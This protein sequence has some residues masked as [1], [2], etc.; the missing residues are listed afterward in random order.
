MRCPSQPA[1]SALLKSKPEFAVKLTGHHSERRCHPVTISMLGSG[2]RPF[3]LTKIMRRYVPLVLVSVLTFSSLSVH[4]QDRDLTNLDLDTLMGMDVAVTSATRRA[5]A[6]ADAAAAVYV[7]TREDIRRSGA[8]TLPE[9]LRYVPG[10]H[11]A[12][13]NSR[14]WAVTSRGSS[15]R[16]ANKLLVMI[17]GRSLYSSVFSGVLWEEQSV[18]LEEI[19]RI[20][21]VRGPGGALWGIN[22]VNGVI[23]VI[24]R[25]AADARGLRATGGA[26]SL[27]EQSAAVSYGSSAE[28]VGDYRTYVDHSEVDGIGASDAWSHTQA[29]VRVDRELANGSFTLQGDIN[30]ADFGAPPPEPAAALPGSAQTG[31]LLAG[32]QQ[33]TQG[34]QLELR[35]FYAWTRRGSPSRWAESLLGFDLQFAAERS[36]AH[37]LTM[38]AGYRRSVDELKEPWSVLSTVS[39]KVVQDQWSIF[40]QDEIHLANDRVRFIAGAKLEDHEFSGLAFQPTLRGLWAVTDSHTVWLAGSRAVRTPSRFELSAHTQI[41][42]FTPEGM[43][44]T[45]QVFGDQNLKAEDLHAYEF[46]WRWRPLQTISVDLALYRHEYEHLVVPQPLAA[47]VEFLPTPRLLLPSQFVNLGETFSEGAELSLEWVATNWMRMEAQGTWQTQSG[48]IGVYAPRDPKRMFSVQTSLD[49]PFDTELDLDWRSV[50]ALPGI[51][52]YEVL[53]TRLAWWL[54]T[55]IEL[56]FSVDNIFDDEHVEFFDDIAL[57]PGATLGRS[58]FARFTVRP[59]R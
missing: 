35:G 50:A 54:T 44:L 27:H 56:S 59:K 32:W 52:G 51:D 7:I 11:V 4:G 14:G 25:M 36:G 45:H 37:V 24:T 23:N 12:R 47:I 38:G 41:S 39:P 43:L 21:I 18:A 46:G 9:V 57:R 49:L 13:I 30:E 5:Q 29:G 19:E 16:F 34:G 17:D 1:A 31:N 10:L 53:N 48:D 6:A 22:A 15:S 40:A 55:G 33:N 58:Y 8:T 3:S 28:F 26:G 2:E 42:G 20:E